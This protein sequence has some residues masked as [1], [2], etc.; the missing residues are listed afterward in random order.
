MCLECVVKQARTAAEFST[1]DP[2][3]RERIVKE[4]MRRLAADSLDRSPAECSMPAYEAAAEL[5]GV[6]DPFAQQKRSH[7]E[8]IVA[9]YDELRDVV[10]SSPD[11]L[12]TAA[13]LAVAGNVIDLGVVG[14]FD[15]RQE[16]GEVLAGAFAIDHFERFRR[17]LERA[18]TLV[19]LCDNAG[20]IVFD[21]LFLETLRDARPS[22]DVVAVVKSGPIINDATA[23]DA[24]AVGLSEVARVVASGSAV[25]GTPYRSVSDEVR[26]LLRESDLVVSKGQGNFETASSFP[27]SVYFMLKAKCSCVAEELGVGFGDVV[28]L[29]RSGSGGWM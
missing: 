21:K 2:R 11:P 18:A 13:K 10:R 5:S 6:S 26:R 7:N 3:L 14:R 29:H 16:I 24:D 9:M 17:E 27:R 22:L 20:E 15:I 23:E 1:T 12:H 28:F 25:I 8:L 4:A 19:A